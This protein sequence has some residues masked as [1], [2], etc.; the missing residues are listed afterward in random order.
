MIRQLRQVVGGDVPI[1]LDEAEWVGRLSSSS[2]LS[3]TTR[4]PW[5]LDPKWPASGDGRPAA[6][7]G[8]DLEM[9]APAQAGAAMIGRSLAEPTRPRRRK[10]VPGVHPAG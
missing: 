3:I 5:P 9:E 4:T 2:K 1:A 10:R 7:P 6:G 8:S